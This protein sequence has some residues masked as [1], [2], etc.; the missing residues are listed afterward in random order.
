MARWICTVYNWVYGGDQEGIKFKDLPD[1]WTCH[2]CGVPK[3]AF[4]LMGR[5]IELGELD[6]A[7]KRTFLSKKPAIID[8]VVG[9][10]VM[11][12]AIIR[13]SKD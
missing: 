8:V 4:E 11:A 13:V 10:N 5:E 6:D 1:R 12:P 9:P 2:T 3:S 7:L